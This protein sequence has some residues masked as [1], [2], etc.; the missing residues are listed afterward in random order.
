M[1]ATDVQTEFLN[2]EIAHINYVSKEPILFTTEVSK[3]KIH[4]F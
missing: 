2:M 3:T 1:S 4:I